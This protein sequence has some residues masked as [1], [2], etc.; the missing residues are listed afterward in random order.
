M[1]VDAKQATAA[2]ATLGIAHTTVLVS[3]CTRKSA[4]Q[5][6][7]RALA[8]VR[9]RKCACVHYALYF[10]RKCKVNKAST[11]KTHTQRTK[12]T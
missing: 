6:T 4:G 1:N 2:L 12:R 10:A 7:K 8:V 5:L 11:I 3:P 9:E